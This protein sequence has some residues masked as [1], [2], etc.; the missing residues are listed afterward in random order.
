MRRYV[1]DLS[2]FQS[3]ELRD[4]QP[5]NRSMKHIA[6]EYDPNTGIIFATDKQYLYAYD[7]TS[8][9]TQPPYIGT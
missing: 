2:S 7:G 3:W 9:G 5:L 1:P 4:K 6:A 8:G